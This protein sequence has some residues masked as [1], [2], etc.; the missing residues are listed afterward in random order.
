VVLVD[1]SIWIRGL[2][3]RTPYLQQLDKLL[4]R[5]EVIGHE[6]VYGELLVGDRGGRRL[7]LDAYRQRPWA[8]AIPHWRVVDFVGARNLHGRGLSWIDAHL[9]ASA[10]VDRVQLWTADERFAQVAGELGVGYEPV[11]NER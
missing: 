11:H 7:L 8:S 3:N 6:L 1:T 9:L 4:A 10:L 5:D 2:A